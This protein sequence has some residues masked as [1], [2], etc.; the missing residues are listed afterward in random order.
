MEKKLYTH[1]VAVM[2]TRQV[3]M[4][5]VAPNTLEDIKQ[6]ALDAYFQ[7][8][9]DQEVGL[10]IP[11]N[12]VIYPWLEEGQTPPIGSEYPA[13]TVISLDDLEDNYEGVQVEEA[14]IIDLL[15]RRNK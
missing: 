3:I 10:T 1:R 4:D 5:V 13:P 15:T 6:V 11:D 8:K 14:D 2:E 12:L 9:G 7:G